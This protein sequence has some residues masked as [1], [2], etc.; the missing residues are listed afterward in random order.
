VHLRVPYPV[1]FCAR[2]LDGRIDD[3]KAR[4]KGRGLCATNAVILHWDQETGGGSTATLVHFQVRP[5]L[6]AQ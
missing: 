1:G 5:S 3:E 4:W 6:L 2:T